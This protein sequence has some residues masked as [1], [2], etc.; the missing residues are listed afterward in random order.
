MPSRA[1]SD[2]AWLPAIAVGESASE[3]LIGFTPPRGRTSR[4]RVSGNV[5]IIDKSE[6]SEANKIYRS[7]RDVVVRG[8]THISP[9]HVVTGGDGMRRE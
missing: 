7:K 6:A 4:R 3:R 5:P 8:G 2:R 9:T 1:S